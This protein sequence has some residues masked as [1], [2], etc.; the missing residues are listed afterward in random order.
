MGFNERVH[1]YVAAKYYQHLTEAFGERGRKAF[2]HA[3]MYYG[4]RR[5][6][7][8][9]QKAIRDGKELT[10]AVYNNYSEFEIS[11]D[12]KAEGSS[13]KAEYTAEGKFV[14]IRCPWNIQ[15]AS[16]GL[17]EAGR[18][19]C[20][21]IDMSISRGFNPE[22][23]FKTETNLNEEG[24][25]SCI[26]YIETGFIG[27]G[28]EKGKKKEYIKSFE[29]HTADLYWAFNEVTAS[30]FEEEGERVNQEVMEDF[31]KDYGDEMAEILLSYRNKNFNVIDRT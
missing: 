15:F 26:Q 8:M 23:G 16:M 11:E 2:V 18:E 24:S 30:I 1:A 9:A 12:M 3:T 27:E 31:G 22:L 20:R 4:G 25:K 7:R 13:N 14:V 19:Y 21:N 5:G 10:Q 6:R 29:Y 17:L 28:A